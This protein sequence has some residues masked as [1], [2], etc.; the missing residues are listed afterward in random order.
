MLLAMDIGNSSILTGIFKGDKIA[1]SFRVLT[2]KRLKSAEYEKIISKQFTDKKIKADDINAVIVSSVVPEIDA[3]FKKLLVKFFKVTPVFVDSNLNL[4]IKIKVKSPEQ[5][6]AD[7]LAN[8]CAA[9]H[10]VK[11]NIIVIDFGTAT[12]FDYITKKGEFIG[13]VIAPGVDVSFKAL[14]KK[15]S[16][17]KPVELIPPKKVIG[18]DTAS[19]M[20][21]GVY[22]GY[23]GLVE[24]IV[25]KM[26]KE[27]NEKAKVLATGGASSFFKNGLNIIDVYDEHLILR[28]L[29][30]IYDLNK[31]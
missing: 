15:A 9:H 14:C 17:L 11:G 13:G 27:I 18:K 20:Q 5:I 12:T 6:G 19:A 21:S 3:I 28:G 10:S 4:G 22:N 31:P 1:A 24:K 2:D 23:I 16:K 8:A 25:S 26:K 30:R 29:N 7:R